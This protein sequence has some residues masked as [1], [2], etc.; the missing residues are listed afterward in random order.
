MYQE[1]I[2]SRNVYV[3]RDD[4]GVVRQLVH[5]HAPVGSDA[6]TPQLV[7][8]EYLEHFGDLLGFEPRQLTSLGLPPADTIEDAPVEYRFLDEKHQFDTTT[9]AYYQTDLGL[10]VWQAGVAVQMKENPFRV[11][12]SQSTVHPDLGVKRPPTGAAKRAESLTEEELAPLLG[13]DKR[14]KGV[15]SWDRGSLKIERRALVIFRYERKRRL[16][17]PA[18]EPGEAP[19]DERTAFAPPPPTLPLPPVG[20]TIEDGQHYVC[21][22]ID[23]ALGSRASGLLHWVAIIEVESLSVL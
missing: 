2:P 16:A 21:A 20:P 14:T 11:I 17:I 6:R 13:L 18:S 1:F 7:A 8:A 23:F 22:K 19:A 10:P 15:N 9:V 5:A 12:S 4:N 3:D